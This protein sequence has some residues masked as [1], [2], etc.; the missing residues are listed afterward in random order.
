MNQVHEV[1][2]HLDIED[3]AFFGLSFRQFVTLFSAVIVV[4]GLYAFALAW[5][6]VGPRLAVAVPVGLVMAL[7]VL[8]RPGGLALSDWALE[9][10]AFH[11]RVRV[12]VY[13]LA[14]VEPAG[15]DPWQ[16]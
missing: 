15:P 6:P 13:N 8:I 12:A 11:F 9:R 10:L 16:L 1:P 7:S 14:V 2:T 3:K 5:L 4:W